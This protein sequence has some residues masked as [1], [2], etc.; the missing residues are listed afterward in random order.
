[1]DFLARLNTSKLVMLKIILLDL[2]DFSIEFKNIMSS[3][4]WEK[5]KVLKQG[6]FSMR[7]NTETEQRKNTDEIRAGCKPLHKVLSLQ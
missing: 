3:E 7:V 2:Q 6:V 4:R 1:M 5:V